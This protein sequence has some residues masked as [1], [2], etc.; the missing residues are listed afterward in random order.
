ME[1]K[2]IKKVEKVHDKLTRFQRFYPTNIESILEV[3][4]KENELLTTKFK[5][6]PLE[7]FKDDFSL[8]STE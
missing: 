6:Y 8:K 2:I 5:L 7:F 1:K 4:V 3:K